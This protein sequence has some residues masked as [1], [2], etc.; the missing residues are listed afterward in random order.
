[1]NRSL[2]SF[3][4]LASFC[5]LPNANATIEFIFT[6]KEQV[7][8]QQGNTQPVTPTEWHF[9]AGVS[10]DEQLTAVSVSLP[11]ENNATSIVGEDGS[12]ELDPDS[13]ATKAALDAAYPNGSFSFSITDGGETQ[14]LGPFSITGDGYPIAPH[15]TNAQALQD[16]NY[17]QDF[18]VTWNAFTG[19]DPEDRVI[20]NLYD[21]T[22]DEELIFEFLDAT[23]TSFTIPENTFS[24]NKY[25]EVDVI[26][27]NETGGL[28]SPE[29]IIGYLSTTSFLLYTQPKATDFATWLQLFFTGDDLLN[30]NIAGPDADPDGDK[31]SNRFEFLAKLSPI[32]NSST[33]TYDFISQSG[34]KVIISPIYDEVLWEVQSSTDLLI[35]NTIEPE[36]YTVVENQIQID[37]ELFLPNTFFK[38]VLSPQATAVE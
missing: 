1:M 37:L 28:D 19:A 11:G 24:E 5:L 34:E 17:A 29:T 18:I 35:W 32:D 13:L 12:F 9:G 4:L 30:P 25:Y 3:A 33:L 20:F 6:I 36:S 10:G 31:L 2:L 7:F 26:F 22:D 23:A 21:D 14:D 8:D 27:V 38:V 16:T 15:I